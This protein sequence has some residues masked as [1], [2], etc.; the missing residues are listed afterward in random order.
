MDTCAIPKWSGTSGDILSVSKTQSAR[1]D[2]TQ[3]KVF[4]LMQ[5]ENSKCFS[6]IISKAAGKSRIINAVMNPTLRASA[7][8]LTT[9]KR[10]VSVE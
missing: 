7:M 8:S 1:E 6:S 4:S 10:T 5:K 9:F 3:V 2:F